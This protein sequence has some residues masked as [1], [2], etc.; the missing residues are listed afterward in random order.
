[1]GVHVC[2]QLSLYFQTSFV[3]LSLALG[4]FPRIS[5]VPG[6]IFKINLL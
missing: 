3:L 1:M 5:C 2:I 6:N 4:G